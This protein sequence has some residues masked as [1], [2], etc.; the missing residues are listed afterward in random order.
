MRRTVAA[1]R[2][3]K[4]V[5]RELRF[6]FHQFQPRGSYRRPWRLESCRLTQCVKQ[7]AQHSLK[8]TIT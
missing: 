4:G 1:H 3:R 7:L 6:R 5:L 2:S 8:L